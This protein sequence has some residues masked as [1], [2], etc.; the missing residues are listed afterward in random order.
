MSNAKRPMQLSEVLHKQL[1]LPKLL[2]QGFHPFQGAPMHFV[3]RTTPHA[4][5][6]MMP[7]NILEVKHTNK[8]HLTY[9]ICY[10]WA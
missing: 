8:G 10:T 6:P 5:I 7:N 9:G 4:R 2:Q 1:C 3:G